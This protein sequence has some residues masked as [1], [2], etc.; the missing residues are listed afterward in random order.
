MARASLRVQPVLDSR[1]GRIAVK[2]F[3]S[4]GSRVVEGSADVSNQFSGLKANPFI[5]LTSALPK[6]M[7]SCSWFWLLSVGEK[8]WNHRSRPLGQ[9][10]TGKKVFVPK[11]F[12]LQVLRSGTGSTD[13]SGFIRARHFVLLIPDPSQLRRSV[14]SPIWF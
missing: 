14:Q 5:W 7:V 12:I 13:F 4:P 6:F 10:S 11:F 8:L 9:L 1:H 3:S 2:I